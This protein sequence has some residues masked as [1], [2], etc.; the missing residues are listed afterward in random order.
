MTRIAFAV[1]FGGCLVAPCLAAD[2]EP[3][4]RSE[5]EELRREVSE[6]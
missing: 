5:V 6:L 1:L 3:V 4:S 2:P